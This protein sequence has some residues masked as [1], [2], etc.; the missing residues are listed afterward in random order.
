MQQPHA[1]WGFDSTMMIWR[2]PTVGHQLDWLL[3]LAC[4]TAPPAHRRGLEW[5][6]Y[7]VRV[8]YGPENVNVQAAFQRS[9]WRVPTGLSLDGQLLR[10]RRSAETRSSCAFVLKEKARSARFA[11][12]CEQV[13]CLS[14]A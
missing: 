9:G 8:S 4:R 2:R 5:K 11:H 12:M 1:R 13:G 3:V 7:L 14:P 6:E 10:R